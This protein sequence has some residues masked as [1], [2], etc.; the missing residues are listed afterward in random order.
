MFTEQFTQSMYTIYSHDSPVKNLVTYSRPESNSIFKFSTTYYFKIAV[1]LTASHLICDWVL[2][3][4]ANS[5][6][7][8]ANC[9]AGQLKANC[10]VKKALTMQQVNSTVVCKPSF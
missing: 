3:K 10:L 7:K 1:L 5:V 2:Y 4:A 6:R 8:K 9:A